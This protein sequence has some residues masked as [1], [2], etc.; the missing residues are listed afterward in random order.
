MHTKAKRN[1]ECLKG[2]NGNYSTYYEFF[3]RGL[4]LFF[5]CGWKNVGG[6]GANGFER[7]EINSK[8]DDALFGSF[9]GPTL[10]L[11]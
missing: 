11:V 5:N 4:W 10:K 6:C 8:N 3:R 9:V 7:N 2:A 1:E